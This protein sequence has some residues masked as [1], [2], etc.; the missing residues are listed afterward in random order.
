MPVILLGDIN[1][2]F[3]WGRCLRWLIS[4]FEQVPAQQVAAVLDQKET[5]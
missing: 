5:K 1:E 4:H 3:V 2:W